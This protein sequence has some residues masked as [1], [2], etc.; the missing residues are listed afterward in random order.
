AV[1]ASTHSPVLAMELAKCPEI[2]VVLTVLNIEGLNIHGGDL[3]SMHKAIKML[4][5]SGKG[6]YLMKVLGRGK[7]AGRAKE[8]LSYAF[9]IPY[10]HAVSVGIR[11]ISE[12][13]EA[14]RVEEETEPLF[15]P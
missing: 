10:V 3:E 13:E 6:V 1:G 15:N 4:Y 5:D 12:L 2:D 9:R 11:S 8:A 14:V 7:L